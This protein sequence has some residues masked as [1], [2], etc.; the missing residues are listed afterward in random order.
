MSNS[1]KSD[2]SNLAKIILIVATLVLLLIVSATIIAR[3]YVL[4]RRQRAIIAE[5]IRNG[6][7]VFPVRP[8]LAR[9]PKMFQVAITKELEEDVTFRGEK[10]SR[11]TSMEKEKRRMSRYDGLAVKWHK[12]MVRTRDLPPH[13]AYAC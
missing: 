6:T 4:R 13:P 11:R 12:M 7:Y 3:S 5:A 2:I 8:R 9:R 1:S 10:G